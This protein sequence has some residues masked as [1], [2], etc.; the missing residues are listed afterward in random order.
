MSI[1]CLDLILTL[2]KLHSALYNNV[3]FSVSSLL[4]NTLAANNGK[5][6]KVIQSLDQLGKTI[7]LIVV[8]LIGKE[9]FDYALSHARDLLSF[10]QLV[11]TW[12]NY[13][14]EKMEKEF[15]SLS[16]RASDALLQGAGKLE[17][18]KVTVAQ[19]PL[20]L[21][22]VLDWRK[23][24]LLFQAEA[25]FHS[26]LKSLVEKTLKCGT[27]YQVDCGQKNVNFE[28]LASFF[29]SIFNVVIS[30]TECL[31]HGG[32]D[33]LYLLV[34]LGFHYGRICGKAGMSAQTLT[35]FDKVLEISQ[36]IG[37]CKNGHAKAQFPSQVC[38]CVCLLCKAAISLNC[39]NPKSQIENSTEQSLVECNRLLNQILKCK[40]LSSLPLKLISD[41]LEYFRIS[42]QSAHNKGADNQKKRKAPMPSRRTFSETTSLLQSYV[43]ILSLQ[44]ERLKDD[45][46]KLN[47]D[48]SAHFRQ[49]LKKIKD[50][51]LGVLSF[52]ISSFQ[53]QL[54][55]NDES[56]ENFNSE[57]RSVLPYLI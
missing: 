14:I 55:L 49:Q 1:Y 41:A 56:V 36:S 46:S 33:S 19:R 30:K 4:Y 42:L 15:A 13:D 47:C 28:H 16:L 18:I 44:C 3:F 26:S 21:C 31:I 10:I 12:K 20:H 22:C 24:S 6:L 52:I 23:V 25:L 34:E 27:K 50:R 48:S 54:K 43:T 40:T 45:I 29:E 32:K 51:Q 35:V 39:T 5:Y 9:Q 8:Q 37:H 11:K 57:L 53:D 2:D 38:C 7:Y 17:E